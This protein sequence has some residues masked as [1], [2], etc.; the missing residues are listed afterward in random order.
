MGKETGKGKH[1]R[2]SDWWNQRKRN[3]KGTIKPKCTTT[4][5]PRNSKGTIKPKCTTTVVPSTSNSYN[6]C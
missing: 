1:I 6:C 3:S 5:V 4:V 2:H